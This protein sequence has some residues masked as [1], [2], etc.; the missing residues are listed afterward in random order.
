MMS[1]WYAS[2]FGEGDANYIL[3]TI[4][5]ETLEMSGIIVFIHAILLFLYYESIGKFEKD[6]TP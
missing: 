3:L 5:E 2:K 4:F 1:G 6:T